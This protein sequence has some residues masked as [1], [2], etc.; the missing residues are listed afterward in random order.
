MSESRRTPLWAAMAAAIV[1]GCS[2]FGCEPASEQGPEA[3]L[4][5]IENMIDEVGET[6]WPGNV[7][8]SGLRHV[9]RINGFY[10]GEAAAYWFAGFASRLPA[11][12][13]WFCRDGDT[14]C[15]MDSS[16]TIDRSR[17]V[18]RP[19][20]ARIPGDA[21][22]SPFWRVWVVDVPSHYQAD[23]IKS[24][25]GIDK[26]SGAGSVTVRPLVFDHGGEIGT[27]MTIMHC[28]LVLSDTELQHNGGDMINQPG[29]ASMP[30]P[31]QTGW[32]KQHQVQFFDFTESE[33]VFAPAVA[34]ESVAL[35]RTADIFVMFRNC[36][37]GSQVATCGHTSSALSA[38]S[39]RG[40]EFD[41]NGDNDKADS[42]N[43]ISGFP[44]TINS[45]P[46][47]IHY[48]PLWRVMRVRI[49][50]ENDDAVPLIDSTGDQN[51]SILKTPRSIREAAAKGLVHPPETVSEAAA[52]DAIIGND[53]TT[54]FNCPAQIPA[55]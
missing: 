47:D 37:A 15:P 9:R 46:V 52:G 33:G 40:I 17:T 19:V 12:V 30:V 3:D 49:E 44:R 20:F 41:L 13:F 55:P 26:A 5:P 34:T 50:P 45:D 39:E 29:T 23:E 16:G 4:G 53:M 7:T 21:G 11:D 38:V 54:F 22:F 43:I 28:L 2:T 27:D 18:G 24:V 1:L 32:H 10:D 36:E 6:M 8:A 14:S 31:A 51:D 35:M 42:N 25:A 48:S